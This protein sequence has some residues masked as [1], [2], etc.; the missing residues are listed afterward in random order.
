MPTHWHTFKGKDLMHCLLAPSSSVFIDEISCVLLLTSLGLSVWV[1]MW[2]SCV[3]EYIL[4]ALSYV[5]RFLGLDLPVTKVFLASIQCCTNVWQRSFWHQHNTISSWSTGS[6][7]LWS[8]ATQH[9]I[10]M[11]LDSMLYLELFLSIAVSNLC[12]RR[13]CLPACLLTLAGGALFFH[14]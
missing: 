10:Y 2:S 4:V 11:Q 12:K 6:R 9:H 13:L 8:R 14:H 1:S 3:N 5:F 7:S